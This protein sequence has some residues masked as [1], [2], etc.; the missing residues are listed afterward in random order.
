MQF[1]NFIR[2]KNLLNQGCNV[3]YKLNLEVSSYKNV[4][5]VWKN[6]K[7]NNR[8]DVYSNDRGIINDI[9]N[10]HKSNIDHVILY[11]TK[12]N[13]NCLLMCKIGGRYLNLLIPA[14]EINR[15]QKSFIAV[16]C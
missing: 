5:D 10:F 6:Y 14:V 8:L 15:D 11:H 13:E 16:Y 1:T 3:I 9:F 2:I 12:Y 4:V 7:Y